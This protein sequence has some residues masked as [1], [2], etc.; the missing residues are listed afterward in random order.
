[1]TAA[2]RF[3]DCETPATAPQNPAVDAKIAPKIEADHR[4]LPAA[5][6][7]PINAADKRIVNGKADINQL[8]PFKYPWAWEFAGLGLKGPLPLASWLIAT[9]HLRDEQSPLAASLGIGHTM[10]TNHTTGACHVPRND[11]ILQA[12]S[13][14]DDPRDHHQFCRSTRPGGT[15]LSI[16]PT[17][18][19]QTQ[20]LM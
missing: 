12:A 5:A 8:A 7:A 2:Y 16:A 3:D 15:T 19:Q 1:M 13:T 4:I 17:S 20:H 6:L 11:Q 9:L 10:P 14:Q 18:V